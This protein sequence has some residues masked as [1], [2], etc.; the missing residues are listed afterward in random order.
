MGD[1]TEAFD[2]A[3]LARAQRRRESAWIRVVPRGEAD[4]DDPDD[5]ASSSSQRLALVDALSLL[6][7]AEQGPNGT[8]PRL[9]R[10]V[11]RV[12]KRRG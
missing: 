10:S 6:M 9:Q 2:Q 12:L 3:F 7:I 4:E 1:T 5:A 8:Q 11:A